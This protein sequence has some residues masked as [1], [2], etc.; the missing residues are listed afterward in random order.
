[1]AF[2]AGVVGLN[3]AR[4][5]C[6]PLAFWKS[7]AFPT[8]LFMILS[9]FVVLIDLFLPPSLLAYILHV[10]CELRGINRLKISLV[11]TSCPVSVIVINTDSDQR[12]AERVCFILQVHSSIMVNPGRSSRPR[13]KAAYWLAPLAF[14]PLFPYTAQD[15]L[16][17][18]G[19]AHMSWA[20][21]HQSSI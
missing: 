13:R 7:A 14:L 5:Y 11:F 4:G 9:D 6:L 10:S 17:R 19:T 20:S 21:P 8:S 3:V 16:P 12:E 15:H 2:V 18:G 1:M